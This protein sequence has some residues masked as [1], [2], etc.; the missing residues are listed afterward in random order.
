MLA[1][2]VHVTI[3]RV[4][5]MTAQQ[6]IFFFFVL[7]SCSVGGPLPPYYLKCDGNH[8]GLT[9]QRLQQL[10]K[11]K[12]FFTDSP[13]PLLSWT[14]AHTERTVKQSAFKVIV[15]TDQNLKTIIWDSGKIFSQYE[16]SLTYAGPPLRIGKTYFWRVMWWDHKGD[17]ALSEEM[18]HFLPAVLDPKD[19]DTAKWIAAGNEIKTAPYL[20]K[21][22]KINS[23]KSCV[24]NTFCR[25][26]RI[27]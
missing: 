8:V 18:G 3:K 11:H 12:V 17:V 20:Y 25:W 19:W 4:G 13:N 10:D 9:A 7:V 1:K 27:Q 21:I 24:C 15:A 23:S 6:S 2:S 26:A 22:F 14:V 16:A 5:L